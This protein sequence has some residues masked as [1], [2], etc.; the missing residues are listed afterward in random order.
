[1]NK[2]LIIALALFIALTI[3]NASIFYLYLT[4][5]KSNNATNYLIS[6]KLIIYKILDDGKKIKIYEGQ[7]ELTRNFMFLLMYINWMYG[8]SN[9]FSQRQLYFT[10]CV[11]YDCHTLT[12]WVFDIEHV[13]LI[14]ANHT[15]NNCCN[16]GLSSRTLLLGIITDTSYIPNEYYRRNHYVL[17]YNGA[18]YNDNRTESSSTYVFIAYSNITRV[19]GITYINNTFF[20]PALGGNITIYG[21][22]L[23]TFVNAYY[24]TKDNRGNWVSTLADR[25]ELRITTDILPSNSTLTGNYAYEVIYSF[26]NT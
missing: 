9:D 11:N 16:V 14:G 15:L 10:T 13:L 18:T 7:D 19:N 17:A 23:Y 22:K 8:A 24:I 26:S 3:I 6:G 21:F 4:I 2:T 25:M 1:M 20:I 12:T 5:P